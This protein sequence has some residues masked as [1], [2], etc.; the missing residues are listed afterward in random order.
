VVP[1][2]KSGTDINLAAWQNL[3]GQD[4][5]SSWKSTSALSACNVA[6]QTKD[7][8]ITSSTYAGAKISGGKA[9]INIGTNGLGGISGN[10]AL[11]LDGVS[12]VAGLKGSF[13]ASSIPVTGS[14]V[15]TMTASSTTKA[16]T[17][18]MTIRG[19][20]GNITH[21]VTVSLV[22]P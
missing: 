21:T 2:P 14:A 5:S 20:L 17:Y 22:V 9:T 18:P 15:L 13:S 4:S 3:T 10:V 7:F 6:A 8:W 11:S 16:G 1:A 12:S 19:N